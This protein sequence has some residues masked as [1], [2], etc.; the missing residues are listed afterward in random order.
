MCFVWL[1]CVDNLS[2][3]SFCSTLSCAPQGHGWQCRGKPLGCRYLLERLWLFWLLACL[4]SCVSVFS[5]R[6]LLVLSKWKKT[7]NSYG[8]LGGMTAVFDLQTHS[9]NLGTSELMSWVKKSDL[10]PQGKLP[11]GGCSIESESLNFSRNLNLQL[12]SF[13]NT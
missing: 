3:F 4:L 9:R 11:R 7:N 13:L 2:L 12:N 1:S 8:K 10:C 5:S 6:K